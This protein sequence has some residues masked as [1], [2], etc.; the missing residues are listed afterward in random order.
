MEV[1]IIG[2]GWAGL[3]CAVEATRLGHHVTVFE[4]ARH[5]G[6]RARAVPGLNLDGLPLTFDNG[7]HILIGAYQETLGLLQ[8]IG[9]KEPDVL[10]RLPLALKFP[11]QSG[12]QF[13]RWP[14]PFDALAGMVNAIGWTWPDKISLLRATLVWQL[15]G[16]TCAAS[17]S[18]TQLCAGMSERIMNDMIAP[19]CVSALNTPADRASG[20]VFLRVM[21]D[22]LFGGSG[23]SNLLLPVT[24]LS[25]LFP[26]T[27]SRW[28]KMHGAYIQTAHRVTELIATDSPKPWRVDGAGYDGVVV[29]LDSANATNLVGAFAAT[30]ASESQGVRH[31]LE[32]ANSL[33]YEAITTV[34]A[35]ADQTNMLHPMLA[36]KSDALT[37]PAQFV[38]DRGQLGG[39][40]G[41][42]AFV[43]SASAMDR[44]ECQAS[45]VQQAKI[46]LGLDITPLQTIVEK[47]A[48]FACT[49]GLKRPAM[50]VGGS[51]LACGDYIDGPYPATLEGAVRSGLHAARALMPRATKLK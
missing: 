22:A 4:A 21:K 10:R 50:Q 13:G 26:E 6:G 47:R 46:Q 39:P 37:N 8:A 40:N 49:P 48:T 18:V 45:V 12:L 16:F 9:L 17:T 51:L 35:M 24:N 43:V 5:L 11:D 38:F 19:L 29:A 34:Y 23:S 1:A 32:S 25:S 31:W 27:A 3:S 36:L 41:L 20:Q 15:S 7:Q 14:S 30:L 42:L 2:G 33:T 44:R 28:L